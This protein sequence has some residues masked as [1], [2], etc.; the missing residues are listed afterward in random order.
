MA[1]RENTERKLRQAH[2]LEAVGRLAGGIAHDFNNLMAIVITRATLLERRLAADDPMRRELE[3]IVAAG[4]RASNL[5]RQLLAFSRAQVLAREPLELNAIVGEL[6]KLLAALIGEHLELELELDP[7]AGWVEADRGQL[8]Q[9]ITNLVVNARDAM[10]AGGVLRVATS[11][12]HVDASHAG[13]ELP[14]GDYAQLRV[15]DHGTGMSED[16]LARIFEPFFTT[17]E[18]ENAGLG[19]ATVYG[20][21]KQ[22]GGHIE[23]KSELGVGTRFTVMLPQ[24]ASPNR[25]ARTSAP[26][27]AVHERRP[28]T[29][30]LVED[31]DR[32]RSALADFLRDEAFVVIEAST[33]AAAIARASDPAL[34][35]DLLLTDVIMPKMTGR[36]LAL[37]LRSTRPE[38]RVLF[39]S[40]YS[41][42]TSLL[43]EVPGSAWLAKPFRPQTLLERLRGLLAT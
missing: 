34:A 5:T 17:K 15:T 23:V 21:V 41:P 16:M 8:E 19:L 28:T 25:A 24:I 42:E 2:K 36:A 22:S 12:L 13:P 35:I 43:D 20:I 26:R 6:A 9:V 33:G 29:I 14:A 32:V 37:A 31:N 30:L 3:D 38:L 4:E 11:S 39:M 1:E 27:I 10:S 7:A 18:G 40:G